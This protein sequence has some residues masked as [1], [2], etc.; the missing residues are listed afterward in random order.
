[1][2][3][4]VPIQDYEC[5]GFIYIKS[6]G[7][8]HR[9]WYDRVVQN[10]IMLRSLSR[11]LFVLG[12]ILVSG[13][14]H[15]VF[16]QGAGITVVPTTIEQAADPGAVIQESLVITNE[17]TEEK[18]YYIYKRDIVGVEAEGVPVF[19]EEGAEKTGYELTEW[20]QLQTEPIR[21]GPGQKF[22][23]P[24]TINV[25]SSASPGSHFGAV[26]VS[27]EPPKLRSIGAGVGYEVGSIIS[28]RIN[29]DIVDNARVR[30][31]STDKLFYGSKNVS[32]TAKIENQGNILIRPRG[33]VTITSMFSSKPR[34]VLVNESQA[35]VFPGAMRDFNFTWSEEG[36]GFGRY[37]AVLALS[38][39]GDG[40]QKTIDSTLVFW[41]FPGK[42]MFVVLGIFLGIFLV[43]YVLTKYYINQAIM[44]AAGGRRISPQRYRK[45]VGVSRF[46]FVVVALLV[47]LVLFLIIL[48]IF[49]A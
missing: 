45:Q 43:G 49:F 46:T 33:P 5:D 21:V 30:S 18:E 48:L 12:L 4:V 37:E 36:L 24:V 47:V 1:M 10:V 39:D 17:S 15:S 25:P 38:Y 42:V 35:G 2:N 27:A 31:F 9:G 16:A 22:T 14:A 20:I 8:N 29:G 26:F 6:V 32:F 41:V 28:I 3:I 11:T 19:A 23:L 34:N 7:K 44:R 40:G 13:S